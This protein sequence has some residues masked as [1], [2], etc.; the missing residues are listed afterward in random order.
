MNVCLILK[1]FVYFDIRICMWRLY[2]ELFLYCKLRI[3]YSNWFICYYCYG[4][5]SKKDKF[6][7]DIMRVKNFVNILVYIKIFSFKWL[8]SLLFNLF[9]VLEYIF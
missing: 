7:E 2:K 8:L 4:S 5:I 6:G 1:K 9:V 3:I